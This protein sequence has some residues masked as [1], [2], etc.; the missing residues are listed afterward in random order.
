MNGLAI[1]KFEVRRSTTIDKG[2]TSGSRAFPQGVIGNY[3]SFAPLQ[4]RRRADD[5]ARKPFAR[6]SVG[7]GGRRR[8]GDKQDWNGDRDVERSHRRKYNCCATV[9]LHTRR[10]AYHATGQSPSLQRFARGTAVLYSCYS[11]LQTRID[12]HSA[13]CT[14]WFN[15]MPRAAR[16]PFCSP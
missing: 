15:T 6:S 16:N 14:C 1:A 12:L 2:S 10:G 9:S 5:G 11:A 4:K 8:R 7:S 3:G 13:I